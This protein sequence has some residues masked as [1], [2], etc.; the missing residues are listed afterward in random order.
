MQLNVLWMQ[1]DDLKKRNGPKAL[2]E[3]QLN[4]A[5]DAVRRSCDDVGVYPLTGS[6]ASK[7]YPLLIF[8]LR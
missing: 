8:L 7:T 4:R 1:V 6:C 5:V 2:T 3:V